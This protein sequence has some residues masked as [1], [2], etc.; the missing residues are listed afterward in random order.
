MSSFSNANATRERFRNENSHE[1][2]VALKVDVI[3]IAKYISVESRHVS[4]TTFC[5]P[6]EGDQQC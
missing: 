5:Q 3:S 2:T 1:V 4:L 6:D